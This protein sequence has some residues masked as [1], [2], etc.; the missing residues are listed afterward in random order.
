MF[1]RRIKCE[2]EHLMYLK[3]DN[4]LALNL[5]VLHRMEVQPQMI[6][7]GAAVSVIVLS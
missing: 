7:L 3:H 1:S 5:L 6:V 4:L 2:H